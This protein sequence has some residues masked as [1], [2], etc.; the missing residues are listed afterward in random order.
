MWHAG[1][2]SNI[3]YVESHPI[4]VAMFGLTKES[5]AN[6]VQLGT[7]REKFWGKDVSSDTHN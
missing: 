7:K 4:I 1:A 5:S 6:S 3:F 2:I